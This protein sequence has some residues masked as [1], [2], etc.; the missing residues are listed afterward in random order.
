MYSENAASYVLSESN[1]LFQIVFQIDH[2]DLTKK[3]QELG[4][5]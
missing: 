3:L 4:M 2:Q 5:E 1:G